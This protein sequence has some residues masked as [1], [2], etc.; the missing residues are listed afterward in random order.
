M[1]KTQVAM[2]PIVMTI[3]AAAFLIG[4]SRAVPP[5]GL[6]KPTQASPAA[7]EKYIVD[8]THS[9]ALFQVRHFGVS[10][11][12]GRF[13][14]ISGTIDV[15][16][17][18]LSNSSVEIVIRTASVNTDHEER[19]TH[20]RNADFF[21]VQKYPTM[22]F[23]SSKIKKITD[24]V[25]EVTGSFT[26]HGVTQTITM[27]VTFLGEFD[28]PW[29][30]HRAGF[31]TSFTIQRSDYGMDKLLG[32]AGDTIQVTLFVEAMRLDEAEKKAVD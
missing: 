22:R 10:F 18:N 32:P 17:E 8:V 13:T 19:D 7:A 12:S 20:L 21:D 26:L 28:V 30:Q 15:D 23:K 5:A 4:Y 11:V 9:A 3:L 1:N 24:T 14:D 31:E 2:K 29:G 16:R 27:N 6:E 25:G